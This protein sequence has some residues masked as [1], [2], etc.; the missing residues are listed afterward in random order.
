MRLTV[1]FAAALL[2][3]WS[4]GAFVDTTLTD[5]PG[6]MEYGFG[7]FFM[8]AASL[9]S[10]G[11]LVWS[12][13]MTRRQ[14]TS[15][16]R[17]ELVVIAVTL[18]ASSMLAATY[19]TLSVWSHHGEERALAATTEV[20]GSLERDLADAYWD[21]YRDQAG[22]EHT[23]TGSKREWWSLDPD[24]DG[25]ADPDAPLRRTLSGGWSERGL[26]AVDLD[27]DL[28][29]DHL[30]WSSDEQVRGWCIPVGEVNG[31]FEVRWSQ[32]AAHGCDD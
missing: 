30:A 5:P 25:T 18:G 13:R 11:G 12:L 16:R 17:R 19:T 27:G 4:V 14:V 26:T 23:Y 21:W 7:R 24:E 22:T 1:G 6:S 8:A 29:I 10:L 31:V 32:A 2:L 9:G 15:L 3:P 28:L 20:R